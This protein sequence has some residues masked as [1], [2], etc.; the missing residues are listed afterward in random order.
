MAYK[1]NHTWQESKQYFKDIIDTQNITLT[2]FTYNDL[3][4]LM[5]LLL[6]INNEDD[7]TMYVEILNRLKT[8][9]TLYQQEIMSENLFSPDH[10]CPHNHKILLKLLL[11]DMELGN[12][13]ESK[14]K[15]IK[16][17]ILYLQISNIFPSHKN[18]TTVISRF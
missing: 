6:K 15:S 14:S 11:K 2:D 16:E 1:Q 12:T 17:S 13:L 3:S 18:I 9:L 8:K 7:D 5:I 4:Q 10:T